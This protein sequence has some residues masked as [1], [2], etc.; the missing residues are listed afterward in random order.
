MSFGGSLPSGLVDFMASQPAVGGGPRVIEPEPDEP[1]TRP[2]RVADQLDASNLAGPVP[3]NLS[4]DSQPFDYSQILS[5]GVGDSGQPQMDT[6]PPP[7][8]SGGGPQISNAETGPVMGMA[9]SM[10]S[11]RD[12]TGLSNPAIPQTPYDRLNNGTP[13][14]TMQDQ[15]YQDMGRGAS[16]KAAFLQG[17]SHGGL[18][19]G[20]L[21]A[22]IGVLDK[23]YG[24]QAQYNQDAQRWYNTKDAQLQVEQRD[25]LLQ[26]RLA[27]GQFEE[28]LPGRIQQQQA[29]QT[30]IGGRQL[31]VG[32][33][34]DENRQTLQDKKD[35]AAL[36]LLGATWD[37]KSKAKLNERFQ[38]I[39]AEAAE[40]GN[41]N[42]G[43]SDDELR[44]KAAQGIALEQKADLAK[45]NAQISNYARLASDSKQRI[46]QSRQR[47][48]IALTNAQTAQARLAQSGASLA[49]RTANE[50][51]V[52][53]LKALGSHAASL[54]REHATQAEI[55]NSMNTSPEQWDAA[56]KAIQG[57][58]KDLNDLDVQQRGITGA[59]AR[60]AKGAPPTPQ[61]KVGDIVK[62]HDGK[63]IK[64]TGIKPNG[65]VDYDEVP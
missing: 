15:K 63:R 14:P 42:H 52:N 30:A 2:R 34:R 5:R 49:Q 46:D 53:Q 35:A 10:P 3:T 19:G 64:I 29:Y 54:R 25:P 1:T 9:G 4:G 16:A 13:M 37:A 61:H 47:I 50:S 44:S 41:I 26:H 45:K 31:A 56:E 43:L 33:Q 11:A 21:N 17:L 18:I 20:G 57:I 8:V 62:T 22:L 55:L 23:G 24:R 39:K 60:G 7:M 36:E 59:P 58:N 48:G 40:I 65:D 32:E 27:V 38:D 12:G 51:I 28:E 6:S